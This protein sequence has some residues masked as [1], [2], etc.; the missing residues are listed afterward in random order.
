[1]KIFMDAFRGLFGEPVWTEAEPDL[2]SGDYLS[3][4]LPWR[5]HD[6]E[7]GLYYVQHGAGWMLEVGG[8]VGDQDLA[9]N[10]AAILA[11]SLPVEA[12]IQVIN[13]TSPDF[14]A[15]SDAW[16][17]ARMGRSDLVTELVLQRHAFL[18]SMRFG[19][20]AEGARA[21]PFRRRIFIAAW[22]E[23][24]LSM[25]Q[26]KRL[27]AVRTAI[28]NT[29]ASSSG[30]QDV[31][32]ETF[33]TL[34]RELFH[35]AGEPGIGAGMRRHDPNIPLN[36]QL[37]GA[38]LRVER[39]GLGFSGKPQM[40][41]TAASV[42]GYPEEWAFGLG[43][44]LAGDPTRL[45]E[46]PV[47]PVLT[48]LTLK[49]MGPERAASMVMTKRTKN[50]HAAK[51]SY[52]KFIPQFERMKAEYDQLDADLRAGERLFTT[53]Y[54]VVAYAAGSVADAELAAGEMASI[55]RRQRILL[56]KDTHLQL[57]LFMAS[58]PF[59]CTNRMMADFGRA[60]RMKLLK[61][62]A[63]AAFMP[64][65][66]E[67]SGN[68]SGPGMLLVGRQ[69]QAF[70]WDNYASD[71]NYNVAVVGKSGAGK[72]VF[73][74][75][76]AVGIFAAGGRVLVIDDGYSF[77]T[78][79]EIL[80][81]KHVAF[82]GR[83]VNRLNPFSLLDPEAMETAEYEADAVELIT[84][85]I[86]SMADLGDNQ[87]GRVR[88]VEEDY[89]RTA[90]KAVWAEKGPE[91]EIGDVRD[92]LREIEGKE[93]RLPDV[94]RK[95]DAYSR[96]GIYGAYFEGPANISLDA[97]F[98]VVELSDVKGQ[99]GL[100]ATILQLVMFLGTELMFKTD[101][102]TPV[103]IVIDE[104]WDL[105][106][107]E[108]TAAFI[109]GVVRR[110]RKYTGALIT[111]TQSMA[112]YQANPAAKVCLENS[113]YRVFLAQKAESI[114]ALESVDPAA[115][116]LLKSIQAVPGRFSEMAIQ[117]T[118]GFVYGRLLLDPFSLAV[119][120]SKGATVQKIARLRDQGLS[121]VEAIKT[122]IEQGEV[123]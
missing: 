31:G 1:M 86:A 29:Y 97:P 52:G 78:T 40:S 19:T 113:D 111:G 13:W 104:A 23:G 42:Q 38:S 72:S 57:P 58:L 34:L 14:R 63:A 36:F 5:A 59:G 26:Q 90:I 120:S 16:M 2:L 115:K 107:G 8:S 30:S 77:K 39:E 93:P 50:E 54:T 20:L 60:M 68:S 116:V 119:F 6:E 105:L 7:T 99:A 47:G 35:A 51:T 22:I 28:R 122:L 49:M 89:I 95:L 100:E 12:T 43:M 65:H 44:F 67:W 92:L 94:V 45:M 71:G 18:Q 32:P 84:R 70:Q 62:K 112:D 46:R 88:G 117:T 101:R 48:S 53:L 21:I 109:E 56:S 98:S 96:G 25:D 11:A 4:I 64:L 123:R 110:A 15:V 91:G 27:G 41:A 37:P 83:T 55:Y 79:A 106:K 75:E 85:V 10:I 118:D 114:D 24:D 3:D 74:Q 108:G 69:G 82:D 17:A 102:A 81:G 9:A 80:E 73:M 76:L 61:T 87:G 121:V 103:A 33:L 66:G